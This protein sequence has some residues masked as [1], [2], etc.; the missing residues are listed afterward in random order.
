MCEMHF[1]GIFLTHCWKM[2]LLLDQ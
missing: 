2:L 1:L